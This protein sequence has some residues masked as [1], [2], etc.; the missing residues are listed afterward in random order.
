MYLMHVFLIIRRDHRFRV[1]YMNCMSVLAS[2]S[3]H[4]QHTRSCFASARR[5]EGFE[6]LFVVQLHVC[7]CNVN[8]RSSKCMWS[9]HIISHIASI[10]GFG[11]LRLWDMVY[12]DLS[13]HMLNDIDLGSVVDRAL[14]ASQGN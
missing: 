5:T 4:Q 1:L 2:A 12:N 7:E 10:T 9:V 6:K 13:H 3:H 8:S 11:C 14:P